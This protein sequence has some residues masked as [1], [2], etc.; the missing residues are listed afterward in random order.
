MSG[1]PFFGVVFF[2]AVRTGYFGFMVFFLFLCVREGK[3]GFGEDMHV[4]FGF[5]SLGN[6]GYRGSV[7][8]FA[9]SVFV[10]S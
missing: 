1:S 8:N 3:D 6:L 4:F 10:T 7:D 2:V 5:G 9:E